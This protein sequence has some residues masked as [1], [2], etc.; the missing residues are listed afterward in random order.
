MGDILGGIGKALGDVGKA[1]G[2]AGKAVGDA[3]SS[4]DIGAK[5]DA[6]KNFIIKL[7]NFIVNIDKL[8]SGIFKTVSDVYNGVVG[9][10]SSV[11]DFIKNFATLLKDGLKGVLDTLIALPGI[12]YDYIKEAIA[13]IG[14]VAEV[15]YDFFVDGLWKLITAGFSLIWNWIKSGIGSAF[16]S[17][18][19]VF[20]WITSAFVRTFGIFS[21]VVV[22][23]FI[24]AILLF[25]WLYMKAKGLI[26]VVG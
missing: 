4:L 20:D 13:V 5:I 18:V 25:V 2:D 8:V 12:I 11:G 1:L 6:L 21:P 17:V 10:V 14:R 19:T 23:V 3:W 22:V 7:Y 9:L 26:P 24:V 16:S 15:V